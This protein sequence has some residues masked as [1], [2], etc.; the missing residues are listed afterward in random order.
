VTGHPPLV[1][2]SIDTEEDDWGAHDTVHPTTENIDHLVELHDLLRSEGARPTYFVNWPPITRA[3]AVEV[4]GRIAEDDGAE[5]GVHCHPWNTPPLA[6]R[7]HRTSWMC[8]QPAELNRAMVGSVRARIRSEL[9]VEAVSFRAGR[10]G[11]GPTVAAALHAEGIRT[12]ASISPFQD[13]SGSGG[14]D[15][16]EAPHRPFRFRPEA[17]LQ[18]ASDGPL[19]ELPTTVGFL[20][21]GDPG[22]QARLR[23]RLEESFLARLRLVGALDRLGLLAR[24]WLSPETSTAREME[25]VAD[26]RVAEGGRYLDLT[27]HSCTLLP[28][29]TPFVGDEHDRAAFLRRIRDFLET[30][31]RRGYRF[32]TVDEAAHTL[33]G[34]SVP[35]KDAVP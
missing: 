3:G 15:F 9:G 21:A 14:P 30:C 28:G 26:V 11:W 10:W 33:L 2:V 32:V 8:A 7:A 34:P 18:P 1:A 24:R 20:R 13:W 22:G 6:Q 17:P 12:D 35:G 31:R 25:R 5:V 4:L 29:A 23:S 19:A 27:F 16:T